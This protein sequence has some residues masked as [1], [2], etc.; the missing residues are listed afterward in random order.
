MA[1]DITHQL[2]L[3]QTIAFSNCL[4]IEANP[5]VKLETYHSEGRGNHRASM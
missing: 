1:S 2:G 5:R 3:G 4:T